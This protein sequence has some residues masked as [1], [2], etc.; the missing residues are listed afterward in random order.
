M[1]IHY[2][3]F[4]IDLIPMETVGGV[5]HANNCQRTDDQV[6]RSKFPHIYT[7][8]ASQNWKMQVEIL[9]TC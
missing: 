7:Q 3:R 5:A 9:S 6:Q 2:G 1:E 8:N 4:E